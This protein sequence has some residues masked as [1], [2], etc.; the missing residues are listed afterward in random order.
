VESD[1][2]VRFLVADEQSEAIASTGSL[3]LNDGNWH[4]VAA[5]K[6]AAND[7]LK[8]YIDFVLVD[9]VADITTGT[10]ANAQDLCVGRFNASGREFSGDIDFI[11]I[12]PE[13]LQPGQFVGTYTQ[14]DADGD[15]IPDRYERLVADTTTTL[16]G[17]DQDGD[18]RSDLIEFA[19]GSSPVDAASVPLVEFGPVDARQAQLRFVQRELPDWLTLRVEFSTDLQTWEVSLPGVELTA[20]TGT[21][22]TP[23]LY[24]LQFEPGTLP[25]VFTR[26]RLVSDQT[27]P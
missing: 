15:D 16:G 27:S 9:D 13:A 21:E 23:S 6:D 4:R 5:V 19:T 25:K 17:G 2:R 10:H 24:T 22:P 7:R 12:T 14:F 8:L 3:R 1:G 11:R 20:N 26:L 18:Q